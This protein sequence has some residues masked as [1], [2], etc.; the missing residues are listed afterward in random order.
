VVFDR[1]YGLISGA[2]SFFEITPAERD[3]RRF[4]LDDKDYEIPK[5]GHYMTDAFTD[6]AIGIFGPA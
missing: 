5:E 1:Y 6:H 3:K 4:V 2:S